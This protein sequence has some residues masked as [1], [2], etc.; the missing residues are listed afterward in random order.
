[1]K[2]A[3]SLLLAFCLAV[4]TGTSA[5]AEA[6]A[7]N[8]GGVQVVNTD[9]AC[10][11]PLTPAQKELLRPRVTD[12]PTTM[13]YGVCVLEEVSD[14]Y[15]QHYYAPEDHFVDYFLYALLARTSAQ[16]LFTLAYICGDLSPE[17]YVLFSVLAYVTSAGEPYRPYRKNADEGSWARDRVK[18]SQNK[19][20]Q[21]QYGVM[22]PQ[23]RTPKVAASQLPRGYVAP[24]TSTVSRGSSAVNSS[25]SSEKP[26]SSSISKSV[27]SASQPK[28]PKPPKR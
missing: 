11:L 21:R 6:H 2:K 5:H 23:P 26:R 15:V 19:V 4:I 14:G 3:I 16:A 18:L 9:E 7:S 27:G 12:D 28:S 24:Q 13:G 17:Q 10:Y 22:A 1:M 25:R 20:L 8:G